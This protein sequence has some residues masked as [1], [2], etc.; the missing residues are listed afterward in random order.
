MQNSWEI[1]IMSYWDVKYYV[2]LDCERLIQDRLEGAV[3]DG[4]RPT[5]NVQSRDQE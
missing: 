5:N 4:E 1:K 2:N 3:D